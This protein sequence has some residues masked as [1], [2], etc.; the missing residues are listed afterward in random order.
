M[1]HT[2][3]ATY[4]IWSILSTT[5]MVFLVSH[6]WAF[7]RFRSLRWG[8]GSGSGAFKRVMTYTY[9]LS[10]PL[11]A[12][13]ACGFAYIKYSEGW[14]DIPGLGVLPKPHE[15]WSQRH[16]D[17]IFPL[18]MLFAV[19]W[20]LEIVTHLEELCFW[21]FLLRSNT[22]G[23]AHWFKSA[24]FKLWLVG[25]LLG[26]VG[27]PLV[28]VFKRQSANE[29]EAW[30]FLIG[31]AGSL[32][33][34][35]LFLPVL[36]GFPSFLR[37]L[38]EEGAQRRVVMRLCHFHD[39]NIIRICFRFFFVLPLFVL[40]LDG[41]LPNPVINH[42]IFWTDLLTF[43]AALGCSASSVMT[44]LI[45]FPRDLESE[46]GYQRTTSS[47][48]S[49]F[50]GNGQLTMIAPHEKDSTPIRPHRP[51]SAVDYEASARSYDRPF[52]GYSGQSGMQPTP[53]SATALRYPNHPLHGQ[54]PLRH[55]VIEEDGTTFDIYG[56][57]AGSTAALTASSKHDDGSSTDERDGQVPRVTVQAP[58]GMPQRDPSRTRALYPPRGRFG[59]LHNS[60][61]TPSDAR[62]TV[63]PMLRH[64]KS[65]I[66]LIDSYYTTPQNRKPAS[67]N[68]V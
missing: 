6:L 58:S 49:S 47:R 32:L 60:E 38:K 24:H 67:G 51:E 44:L 21:L 56:A 45:F 17:M 39:I 55:E 52:S 41:V 61:L 35:L 48:T 65:P 34:T 66:D 57:Q 12:T 4:M 3:P 28:T 25:S 54:G 40:G 2:S 23:D 63:H 64:Y 46:A 8:K 26:F 33:L 53:T 36:F 37:R 10:V 27:I 5:L 42:S 22:S 43:L 13:Y 18:Q 16:Q 62:Q 59:G 15:K 68:Y 14:V 29:S 11:I 1:C 50:G 7:D 19:A 9:L 30:T 31:S 20:G